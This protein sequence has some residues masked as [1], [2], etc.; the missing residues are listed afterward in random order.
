M[1]NQTKKQTVGA[2]QACLRDFVVKDNPSTLKQSIVLHG[3]ERPGSGYIVGICPGTG[4][5]PFELSCEYTKTWRD[6][7]VART[8]PEA[9][10]RLAGLLSGQIKNFVARHYDDKARAYVDQ[11]V[12][13]GSSSN[14]PPWD[15]I[16][17]NWKDLRNRAISRQAFLVDQIENDIAWLTERIS[18]WTYAPEKLRTEFVR[19]PLS[20]EGVAAD[21]A[22]ELKR[23]IREATRYVKEER[24]AARKAKAE[25]DVQTIVDWFK[26]TLSQPAV[27][28][29]LIAS[30]GGWFGSI[31][32]GSPSDKWALLTEILS[33]QGLLTVKPGL[34]WDL[35]EVASLRT[36]KFMK[37]AETIRSDLR[38]AQNNLKAELKSLGI[39]A[40]VNKTASPSPSPSPSPSTPPAQ[41]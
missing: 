40:K 8:L 22:R 20:R 12:T 6:S 2:C 36:F 37:S 16:A 28:D 11:P 41:P 18:T 5:A 19:K 3:Y 17:P 1:L 39:K 26:F 21:K 29:A 7:L 38:Y 34:T 25:A 24:A 32:M 14:P 13:E 10:Q 23:S 27:R 15:A 33:R 4:V 9:K 31:N 30:K 35:N